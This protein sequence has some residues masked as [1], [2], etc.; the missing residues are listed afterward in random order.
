M[1][2]SCSHNVPSRSVT[3][4]DTPVA[5]VPP[6]VD[7]R[8]L[9]YRFSSTIVR[10]REPFSIEAHSHRGISQ[11]RIDEFVDEGGH[12]ARAA[13][14]PRGACVHVL[15]SVLLDH[16]FIWS[17]Y[18]AHVPAEVGILATDQLAMIHNELDM[19]RV[20]ETPRRLG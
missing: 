1:T 11:P 20:E 17:P 18:G 10:A 19:P 13:A 2:D 6:H 3:I 15:V 9:L 16:E 14:A 4:S 8:R 5:M 12:R 7:H